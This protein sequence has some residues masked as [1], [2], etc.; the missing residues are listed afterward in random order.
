MW[1]QFRSQLSS[2]VR[3]NFNLKSVAGVR[4]YLES[5]SKVSAIINARIALAIAIK[6]K[7][8]CVRHVVMVGEEGYL[9]GVVTPN[10]LL[11]ALDPVEMHA[12]VELLEHT[13]AEQ[14]QELMT[15]NER[16]QKKRF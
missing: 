16:L 4:S 3:E 7:Q 6:Y 15:V 2:L 9:A 14:T 5:R 8:H 12:N 1:C 13:V 11:H 10:N